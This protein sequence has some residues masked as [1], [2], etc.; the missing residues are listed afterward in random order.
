MRLR[1]LRLLVLPSATKPLAADDELAGVVPRPPP[2]A[3]TIDKL[4]VAEEVSGPP[5]AATIGKLVAAR[6][7]KEPPP[8]AADDELVAADVVTELSP[9]IGD[10]A[11]RCIAFPS[12]VTVFVLKTRSHVLLDA[13][14]EDAL[15]EEHALF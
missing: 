13:V 11:M 5:L 6:D 9:H 12:S 1:F 10:I 15:D 4:A 7:V 8:P 2:P 14:E 3:A